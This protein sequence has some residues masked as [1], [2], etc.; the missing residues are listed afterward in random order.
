MSEQE[1]KAKSILP[2]TCTCG[3][4][5]L[6][7]QGFETP[8]LY[9]LWLCC[10]LRVNG[11]CLARATATCSQSVSAMQFRSVLPLFAKEHLPSPRTTTPEQRYCTTALFERNHRVLAWL[12]LGT[13]VLTAAQSARVAVTVSSQSQ[14]RRNILAH[15]ATGMCGGSG[16]S[17]LV[18]S[19][20]YK[21]AFPGWSLVPR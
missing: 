20:E 5:F 17:A 19:A 2:C 8:R 1:R 11:S 14:P 7:E 10:T 21:L 12:T 3:S 6:C 16:P 13:F 9:C 15:V 4:S 18:R